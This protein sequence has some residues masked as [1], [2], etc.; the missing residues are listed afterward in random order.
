M[1]SR[2]HS[3]VYIIWHFGKILA[4]NSFYLPTYRL[5]RPSKNELINHD[6]T[7]WLVLFW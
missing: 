1:L 3:L 2:D 4:N 7:I 6:G 5:F